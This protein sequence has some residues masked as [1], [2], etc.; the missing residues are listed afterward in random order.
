MKVRFF[1][2]I[3]GIDPG[4]VVTGYGIIQNTGRI[5]KLLV[6]GCIKPDRKLPFD[7]WVRRT[8]ANVQNLTPVS[9]KSRKNAKKV[10]QKNFAPSARLPP[11]VSPIIN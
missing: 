11:F 10:L 9:R 7:M 1:L 5:S 8:D 4:I 2:I 3:L 6:C